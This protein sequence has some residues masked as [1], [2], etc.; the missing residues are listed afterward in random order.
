MKIKEGFILRQCA[1]TEI[2]VPLGAN[3]QTHKNMMITLSGSA[4][5]L[6]DALVVG[7]EEEALVDAILAEYDIDRETA[8]RDVH[9]FVEK[10]R[11]A[12]LLDE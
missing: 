5:L 1:G 10:L 6:W 9:L 7:C 4:R 11:Q 2:V 12:A 3:M 8:S